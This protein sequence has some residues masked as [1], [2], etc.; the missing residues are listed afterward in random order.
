MIED[1]RALTFLAY[2]Y[3]PFFFAVL[4]VT[5]IGKHAY[6]AYSTAPPDKSQTYRWFFI[7]VNIVGL[8]LVIATSVW[9]FMNPQLPIFIFKG[10]ISGLHEYDEVTSDALYFRRYIPSFYANPSAPIKLSEENFLIVQDKPFDDKTKFTVYF[11]KQGG[12]KQEQWDIEYKSGEEPNYKVVYDKEKDKHDLKPVSSEQTRSSMSLLESILFQTAYAQEVQHD[13]MDS[14]IV[15]SA[16]ISKQDV[17]EGLQSERTP[18]GEKIDLLQF[19]G[20]K[21]NKELEGYL[22][23]F[24]NK[25]SMILTILDL[26]RHTDAQLA[27]YCK[28][29][30][31]RFDLAAYVRNELQSTD[32][33][34][35]NNV[36]ELLSR[37]E[38]SRRK[39]LLSAVESSGV[40][41]PTGVKSTPRVLIPT[42]SLKGDRYYVKAS[43]NWNASQK[44]Q[45][46]DLKTFNCLTEVFNKNLLAK[47]T[48]E[49]ERILMEKLQGKRF[50][51]W[52]TK[53]WTLSIADIIENCGGKATFVN[54]ITFEEPATQ[55]P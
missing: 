31:N 41:I 14:K 37:I 13:H 18:V 4:F 33:Q 47:R 55:K 21:T 54:G 23:S 28:R 27:E 2:Q 39:S 53:E 15:S 3:A 9:W 11:Q 19:L 34:R 44:N 32:N 6:H 16:Q 26:S 50:V 24:T 45:G 51:Y 30:L 42:G 5:F 20:R 17:I 29:L 49:E 38:G 8:I 46:Q 35:L 1:L 52:Y 12:E 10:K 48:I 25:E 7:G 43:W 22:K 40:K 36:A